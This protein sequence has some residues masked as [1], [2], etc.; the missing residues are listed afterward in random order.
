[1]Y[2]KGMGK[3][4]A[5]AGPWRGVAGC[6]TASELRTDRFYQSRPLR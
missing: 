2:K 5:G 6:T 1:M 4:A 3:G